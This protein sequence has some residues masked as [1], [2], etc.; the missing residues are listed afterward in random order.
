MVSTIDR[1][2]FLEWLKVFTLTL[3]VLT[4]MLVLQDMY[5]E[6]PVLL[7]F[8][9]DLES[10]V[11][12]YLVLIPSF[13]PLVLPVSILISLLISVGSLH[14][15]NEI[16]A[17]RS[18]GLSL[19]KI[20][21]TLWLS[22]LVLSLIL[23]YLN[24]HAIPWSVETSRDY[25]DTLRFSSEAHQ[26]EDA[27]EVGR[28][29]NLSFDNA[30]ED[31]LWFMNSF[32]ER[33]YLGL[34]VTVF[35]RDSF[36]REY[37]RIMASEAVYDEQDG[38]WTFLNGRELN[39]NAIGEPI[40]SLGFEKLAKPTYTEDPELM[41]ALNKRPKDLSL[42]EISGILQRISTRDN[43]RIHAY[44]V[45]YYEILAAPFSCLIVVGLAVP[46]A[47]AGVRTSPMVGVS[48]SIG[49]FLLFYFLANFSAILG[50]RQIIP[51]IV[52]A[53]T[54]YILMMGV[55]SWFFYRQR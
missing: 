32:S 26:A 24:A 53:G 43:P 4:G 12:Y 21:R 15:D 13:F 22:G 34:G 35:S 49:Y 11:T 9:A 37:Y 31:R 27:S 17:L 47:V 40:R 28:V 36:G 41:M 23:F 50:E 2:I 52:A 51:A 54:P 18:G 7:S 30:Q 55:G 20:S 33:A 25:V 39:F 48:K 5:D 8:G 38:F 16:I 29:D 14:R 19:W 6:L 44:R 45:Q 3:G 1:Y 42:F 46:F 10:L